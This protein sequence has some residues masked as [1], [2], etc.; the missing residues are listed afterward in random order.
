MPIREDH[1][2]MRE[3]VEI[4]RLELRLRI[5]RAHVA[6]TLIVGVDEDYVGTLR[7]RAGT[8]KAQ[9]AEHGQQREKRRWN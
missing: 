7:A 4:R 8:R 9:R 2:L 3:P 5:Q 6:V 1:S